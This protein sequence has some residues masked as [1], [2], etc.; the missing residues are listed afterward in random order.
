MAALLACHSRRADL[1]TEAVGEENGAEPVV[2][3]ARPAGSRSAQI[4]AF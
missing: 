1:S 4:S 2:A 3:T